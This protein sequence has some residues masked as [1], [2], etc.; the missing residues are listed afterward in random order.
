MVCC[1]FTCRHTRAR[2]ATLPSS[3]ASDGARAPVWRPGCACN[4]WN[5]SAG[6]ERMPLEGCPVL[7]DLPGE[8][9]WAGAG[10]G[11][12]REGALALALGAGV[13]LHFALRVLEEWS[14][15]VAALHA[16]K[17]DLLQLREHIGAAGHHPGC[18]HHLVQVLLPATHTCLS[19]TRLSR[20]GPRPFNIPLTGHCKTCSQRP[21]PFS[22]LL[23]S[24]MS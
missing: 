9:R 22:A 19:K 16:V 14:Q 12:H 11:A 3:T 21:R 10:E 2:S 20:I 23:C 17:L 18:V 24:G 1:T 5:S 6:W 8:G 4:Q 13:G 7:L 15:H